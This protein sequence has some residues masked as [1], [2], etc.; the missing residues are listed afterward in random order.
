MTS[1]ELIRS[2]DEKLSIL[3][4]ERESIKEILFG[5]DGI[6]DNV[7]LIKAELVGNP[8]FK[9]EG[10]IAMVQKHNDF[11]KKMQNMTALSLAILSIGSATGVAVSW[12]IHKWDKI[13]IF[14]S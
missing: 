5:E 2:V 8:E 3:V 1:E 4:K 10:L 14:F 13:K 6:V 11:Y 7:K 9:K 12:I